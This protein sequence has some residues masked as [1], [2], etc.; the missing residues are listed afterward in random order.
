M[1]YD[2]SNVA[3]L[4]GLRLVRPGLEFVDS[5]EKILRW[6]DRGMAFATWRFDSRWTGEGRGIWL[7]FRLTY[8]LEANLD[9][10]QRILGDKV[11]GPVVRILRRRMD[12]LLPPWTTTVDVDIE[13]NPVVDSLLQEI[14]ARPY[15]DREDEGGRRDFNLGSRRDA[16]YTTIGFSELADA[17]WIAKQTSE[18]LLRSSSQFLNWSDANVRH[19]VGELKADNERLKR[20]SEAIFRETKS[21]DCGIELEINVN[22]A[23]ADSLGS[24]LVRLDAIGLFIVSNAQPETLD[25]GHIDVEHS[26]EMR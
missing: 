3:N 17:C 6:D 2:R 26:R 21:W 19:A 15:T 12:S 9:A 11:G 25:E 7:G 23:I 10:A 18:A 13:M 14:L 24:P 5:I 20:R 1:T 22:N 16:L 8:V 4:Q